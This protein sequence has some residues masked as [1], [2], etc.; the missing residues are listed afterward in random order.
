[1]L[2]KEFDR[3][4]DIH[5]AA[6]SLVLSTSTAFGFWVDLVSVAFVAVVTYS[7]IFLESVSSEKVGLAIT[8]TLVITGILQHGMKMAAEMITQMIA[9]ERLFQFTKLEQ[10]APFEK[11]PGTKPSESWPSEGKIQFE[12]LYLRYNDSVDPVL[13]NLNVNIDPGM[14][15]IFLINNHKHKIFFQ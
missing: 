4:Q 6:Y 1:M 10:E 14:K 8:Q 13:K 7:F 5:T 2:C 15:V 12:N 9:V 3:H 11:E